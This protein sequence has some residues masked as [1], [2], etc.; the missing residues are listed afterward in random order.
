MTGIVLVVVLITKFMHGAW[1][2]IVAM[3][4]LFVMMKGIRRHYD[5]VARELAAD[6]DED[7]VLPSRIHAIVLVSKL[8][9]PTLRALAYAQATRPYD[10]RGGH[11][12]RRPGRDPGAA[13]GVGP[14]RHP[15]AAEGARLA[16]PGDHPP[17]HR[18][19]PRSVAAAARATWSRSTSR[20][21]SSA[22]GG[23]TCCT[24]RARCGSRAGCC[25]P[26]V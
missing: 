19:R 6:E 15:G 23:S 18:L 16:V 4:V 2:A 17:G 13:G 1:I 14:P 11:R 22:T 3:V 24:T 8:H 9:K 26:R 20:S 10:A 21:T 5:R 12:Q 7:A 25:S